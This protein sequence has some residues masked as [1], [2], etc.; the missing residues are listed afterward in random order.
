MINMDL[1]IAKTLKASVDQDNPKEEVAISEYVDVSTCACAEASVLENNIS[2]PIS[3]QNSTITIPGMAPN[4]QIVNINTLPFSNTTMTLARNMT[5]HNELLQDFIAELRKA[6]QSTDKHFRMSLSQYSEEDR[7]TIVDIAYRMI[8]LITVNYRKETLLLQG[9]VNSEVPEAK[10]FIMGGY[11]EMGLCEYARKIT[12][13]FADSHGIAVSVDANVTVSDGFAQ[14]E[15]DILI[16]VG[17]TTVVCEVKSGMSPMSIDFEK[18]YL[19][20]QRLG[21]IPDRF[22]LVS[23]GITQE[24]AEQIHDFHH[25]HVCTLQNFEKILLCVLNTYCGGINH[26]A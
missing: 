4:I 6:V 5:H 23:S 18:Y 17:N 26:V 3:K 11:L 24:Q 25:Y 12:S 9:R 8:G 16:R 2:F 20:G 21:V 1:L 14:N 10:R 15:L 13:D 19:L 7:K 22:I